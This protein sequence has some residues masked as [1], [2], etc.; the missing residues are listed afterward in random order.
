MGFGGS[1]LEDRVI[2]GLMNLSWEE[3][4]S[5]IRNWM[6]SGGTS[7]CISLNGMGAFI[8]LDN[9]VTPKNRD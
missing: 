6:S 3:D 4:R 2:D 8:C 5:V 1:I 7:I 9:K